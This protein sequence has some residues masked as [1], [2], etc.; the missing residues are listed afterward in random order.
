MN[1]TYQQQQKAY[2]NCFTLPS[3]SYQYSN[4]QVFHD[5]YQQIAYQYCNFS[6]TL[7]QNHHTYIQ[8]NYQ[9]NNHFNSSYNTNRKKSQSS[10]LQEVTTNCLDL[11]PKT[12]DQKIISAQHH[13][14]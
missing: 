6:P 1:Q 7:Q 14:H 13:Q 12:S 2:H 9:I 8:K 10:G 5:T 3:Y 11:E 4:S